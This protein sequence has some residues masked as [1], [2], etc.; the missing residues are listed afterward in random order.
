MDIQLLNG[1]A[2]P[3]DRNKT[4]YRV[5][6]MHEK[7]T[8]LILISLLFFSYCEK[9][10]IDS[11]KDGYLVF[12]RF[13]G[14]CIGESCV[15]IFKI[16]GSKLYEDT[17]DHY[18]TQNN[19]PPHTSYVRLADGLYEK[20]KHLPNI[21]PNKLFSED[22]MIIGQP[23]AGDWGGFYLETVQSGTVENWLIDKNK[24]NIPEYLHGFVDSLDSAVEKLQ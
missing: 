8:Y 1:V 10:P 16:E 4:Q 11:S 2:L 3:L 22:A 17:L 14:E 23:D 6:K 24:S 13:Y 20:V 12:G 7:R 9:S 21:I 18:P 5:F 15:E 19:L